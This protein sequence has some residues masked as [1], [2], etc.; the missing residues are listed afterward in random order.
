MADVAVI[1]AG[2]AGLAAASRLAEAGF[3]VV[4]FEQG[5][6]LGGRASAF[7]DR[8]TGERVD[9]G[10]HVL[11]GCYE[12]TYAFLRRVGA[13]HLAPL[14]PR[15]ELP[16]AGP[17]GRI[18]ALR[19]PDLP[20]PWHLL[21]G[22][23][24]WPALPWSDRLAALRVGRAIAGAQRTGT[25]SFIGSIDP[26]WTVDD[27][28]DSLRQ[29]ATIRRWLWH[30]L[31]V[32]ALN[33]TADVA[34]ASPF[35]RVLVGLFAPSPTAAAV[36]LAAVPLDE[37]YAEPARRFVEAR[38]GRVLLRTPATVEVEADGVVAVSATNVYEPVR[39]VISSVPWHAFQSIW[40]DD[41]PAALAGVA[42]AASA[43]T[44]SPIVTVNLWFDGPVM[45]A[46]F[47]GMVDAPI[48]WIFN[49][50]AIVGERL[51]HLA[52]VTSAAE[53]LT[54]S[55][56]DRTTA[57][58]VEHLKQVLPRVAHR[59]LER[60]VVVREQRATFSVAPGAPRRPRAE[61]PVRGFF[62]AGDWTDTGLPATIEGA[63]LS[64]HKA[65]DLA[66]RF[67]GRS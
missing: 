27:W 3:E 24:R 59:R 28:L 15:L 66:A 42:D 7:T 53:E 12:E 29:P 41:V 55:S 10:Q 51:S 31:A 64:G 63:A 50:A 48:H 11:F 52:V 22:L 54:A 34:A 62:L 65:A 13:E 33:Q 35:V 4:V 30:P 14:Q 5:P 60:S 67:L 46:Q 38:G 43:T 19:C 16:M 44:S 18:V 37:M 47:I 6:R 2:V 56:N 45:D 8:A 61:T 40:A 20:A 25:E 23:L 49:K 39:A 36:G 9:N 21:A 32:A 58:T 17:D 26:A 57:T 1:G